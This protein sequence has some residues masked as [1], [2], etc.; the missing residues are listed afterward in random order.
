MTTATMPAVVQYD[1]KPGCVEL[2]QMPIPEIDDDH[3]LL[4]VGAVSVCGSDIHQ[5]HA[6]HSWPV[7]TPCILG[8]EFGGTLVKVGKNI[9]GFKEG[10]RVVN[11]TAAEICGICQQCRTGRYNLCQKRRGYGYGV[12]GAMT[13][14]V[15]VPGRT[16][17]HIPDSLPFHYACLTEP[18]CVAYNAICENATIK[19]GDIVV[20]IG[21]G[22]IGNL[23]AR[24]A[25]LRG[26]NPLIVAGRTMDAERLE[27]ALKLGAT[28]IVNVDKE[29][30]EEVVRSYDELGADV[31]CEA[32]GASKPLEIALKLA[33]PDGQVIKVGWSPDNIPIDMNPLVQKN[34]RL[35]GSFSHTWPMWEKVIRLLANGQ[36]MPEVIVGLRTGLEDWKNAFDTM[37]SGKIIKSILEP[38][39]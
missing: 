16:L 39:A 13:Q 33:R 11:E 30:L 15:K 14:Y 25:A 12:H 20:V 35:Q 28:R 18:C 34:L 3:A 29:N 17:H 6:S 23:C 38:N 1:I 9:K 7:N 4:R 26:A 19:P 32:S 22:P 8:H 2:R 31:V 21:P 5:Y 36:M 27:G 37:S 24:M 10:D